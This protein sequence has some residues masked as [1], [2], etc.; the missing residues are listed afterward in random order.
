MDWVVKHHSGV[1]YDLGSSGIAAVRMSDFGFKF[2]DVNLGETYIG[3]RLELRK[4]AASLYNMR[5]GNAFITDGASEANFLVCGA[6]LSPGDEAIAESPTYAPMCEIPYGI[7]ANVKRIKRK[8][9]GNF[10]I[11]IEELAGLISR[12]TKLIILTNLNNPTSAMMKRKELLAI[13]KLAREVGAHILVD[14]VFRELAFEAAPPAACTLGSEFITT[15]SFTKSCGIGGLRIGWIAARDEEII[16]KA[17]LV[18]E[19]TSVCTPV[20]SEIMMVAAFGKKG[21]LLAR[22][23]KIKTANTKIVR[24][25]AQENECVEMFDSG[26]GVVR[27]PMLKLRAKGC[28]S[29]AGTKKFALNLLKKYDTL[30][31]P[32][33]F[34]GE[35][36]HFRFG[37]G[38]NST[39][40]EAGLK[41]ISRAMTDL[42]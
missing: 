36:A 12:K 25:W 19:Y 4:K 33:E 5:E 26:A 14:E 38:M 30:V 20:T 16:S 39:I 23:K 6:L 42:A 11:D 31:S 24:E 1:R 28:K 32:G 13:G 40:L 29:G 17:R 7:G 34:F 10:S 18:K 8:A 35:P 15:S 3:G 9:D 2:G 41:N 21:A 27:F 37:L 22:A